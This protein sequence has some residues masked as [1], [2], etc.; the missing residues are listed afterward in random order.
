MQLAQTERERQSE[1]LRRTPLLVWIAGA[2]ASI[3]GLLSSGIVGH[4]SQGI[5]SEDKAVTGD[6]VKSVEHDHTQQYEEWTKRASEAE[7]RERGD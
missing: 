6:L 7:L 5:R 4:C 2:L 1:D 3:R